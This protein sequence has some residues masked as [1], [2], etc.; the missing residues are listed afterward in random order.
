MSSC[1]CPQDNHHNGR[2]TA[3]N[4]CICS[5]HFCQ[6][7]PDEASNC[8]QA[9]VVEILCSMRCGSIS[10]IACSCH[11]LRFAQQQLNVVLAKGIYMKD[12][13]LGPKARG[14]HAQWKVIAWYHGQ[15]TFGTSRAGRE[16]LG[17][18][19]RMMTQWQ[20]SLDNALFV[21][22]KP[23]QCLSTEPM[24]KRDFARPSRGHVDSRDVS[25]AA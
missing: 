21:V 20:I 14:V 4:S 8:R 23:R 10:N 13:L 19:A 17:T 25:A 24:A 1:N 7:A 6:E 2:P 22:L 11:N 3:V 18:L 5:S 9:V 16:I 15:G 12:N